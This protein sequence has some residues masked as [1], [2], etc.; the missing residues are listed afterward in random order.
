M[1]NKQPFYHHME[2][3]FTAT[4]DAS[5]AVNSPKFTEKLAN[6]LKRNLPGAGVIKESV[7]FDAPCDA[8]AGDPVDLM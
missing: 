3:L 4:E 6:F 1:S 2:I 8:E 7:E 5:S